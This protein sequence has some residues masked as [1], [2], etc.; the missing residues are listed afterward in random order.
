MDR[1]SSAEPL[2]W[3]IVPSAVVL[4]AS[5]LTLSLQPYT[6]VAMRGAEVMSVDRGSPGAAAGLVPGT[7]LE[8]WSPTLDALR[9][10]LAEA[11]PGVPLPLTRERDGAREALRLMPAALPPGERRMM[12]ALLAVA[13]GFLLLG[14][15]VWSER[16][17]RLT[18]PFHLLC[19][20]FAPLLAPLPR[21]PWAAATAA[22]E[23]LYTA[24]TLALPALCIHFFAMFPEPRAATGRIGTGTTIAYGVAASL[25]AT[26]VVAEAAGLAGVGLPAPAFAFLQSLS[27]IW[28]AAGLL[29]AVA[30]FARSYA[31]AASADAR[32]R[33]RVALAGTALGLGPLAG[34]T[35]VRNLT[36]G[37]AFPAERLAIVLTLLVPLSFAWAIAIHRIFDFRVA[38]RA[39][40]AALAMAAVAAVLVLGGELAT[41]LHAGGP[42]FAAM[43]LAGVAVAA[44]AAGPARPGLRSLTSAMLPLREEGPLIEAVVSDVAGRSHS[45]EELLRRVSATLTATL[46]LHRCAAMDFQ[47]TPRGWRGHGQPGPGLSAELMATLDGRS[48]PV[49]LDDLALTPAAPEA[50]EAQGAH[51]ILPVGDQPPAAALLLGRRLAGAWLDRREVVSLERCSQQL[52]VALENVSLRHTARSRGALDRELEEA[53]AFQ[54]RLLPRRAPLH[55]TLDC[56]A[57]TISCEA[58]GGDYYDFIERDDRTFTLVVGDAAGHGVP[59]ALLL[60]GVQAQFRSDAFRDLDPGALL[61]ALNAALARQDHPANF[62]GLLCAR[63][64]V[65]R[66]RIQVANAG[67][68]PPLVRRRGARWEEVTAG[69]LLLGVRAN[70]HYPDARVELG[71]GDLALI[72][73]DGLTEARRGDELFGEERVRRIVDRNAHRRAAD[74]LQ[75]LVRAVRDFSEGPLDDLTVVV[76]KQLTEPVGTKARSPGP[77]PLKLAAQSAEP[78]G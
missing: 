27:A 66:G 43:A 39:A 30:L 75:A 17:D 44:A 21:L 34:L 1:G 29:A 28:F 68:T 23:L 78:T 42:D 55:A 14:G 59:A 52:A 56:A 10:P 37:S 46:K 25:F 8:G 6:G 64:E 69:G 20:A 49:P 53:G 3:L 2:S 12:E 48:G 54:A 51:W 4:I 73:T 58:V 60:A 15:W 7:R 72:Y 40:L 32:R 74:I 19:L 67:L 63:V 65:E 36:P 5:A 70:S 26:F 57:A 13:S 62:V 24:A 71:A 11:R 77:P 45:R 41:G 50:P 76:L 35:V 31:R 18:R 16:R 33:L 9:G 38:L 61:V 47:I 22:H